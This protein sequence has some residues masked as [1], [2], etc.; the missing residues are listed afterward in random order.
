MEDIREG[1]GTWK[2]KAINKSYAE[3]PEWLKGPLL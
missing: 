2:G 1:K 3:L